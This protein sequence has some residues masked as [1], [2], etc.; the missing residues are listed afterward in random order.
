[1]Q[2]SNSARCPPQGQYRVPHISI[3][4]PDFNRV[5]GTLPHIRPPTRGDQIILGTRDFELEGPESGVNKEELAEQGFVIV[6]RIL[7]EHS[8]QQIEGA[9][10]ERRSSPSS[11]TRQGEFFGMRNLLSAVPE[12]ESLARS[13]TLR[14]I[15]EPILGKRS[16]AV[17]GLYF[18]KTPAANWRL[19]WHQDR[20]IAVRE[21][22]DIPDFGPW[23]VKA[24]VQ[25]VF[26]PVDVLA[27]MLTVR[28][29]LDPCD[30]TTGA[31]KVIPGSH[32]G[33]LTE[34][35]VEQLLQ[36]RGEHTCVV[37]RGDAVVMR[38]LIAHGSEK[39]QNPSRRRV[40]HL[41]YAARPLPEPL[42][43]NDYVPLMRRAF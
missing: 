22:F 28:V 3:E 30:A 27:E 4:P 40:V 13:E 43:W 36:V 9:I 35:E 38:P 6:P 8:L 23:S 26:P 12:V 41:E 33:L 21:R 7:S 15:V 2:D 1:L 10:E 24:G 16:A 25:H 18:D 34:A 17:R 5:S 20:A 39:A 32:Q 31:L 14:S 37:E 11:R 29:H 19:G 42:A